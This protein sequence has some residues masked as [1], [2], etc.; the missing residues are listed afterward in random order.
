MGSPLFQKINTLYRQLPKLSCKGCGTCC[1]SPTCT[2]SEF[3]FL[4]DFL[5]KNWKKDVLKKHIL[6]PVEV[7]QQ[8]EGNIVCTFLNDN[9][10]TVYP[11]R[12]G[13]CRLFGIPALESLNIPNLVGCKEHISSPGIEIEVSFL[14]NWLLSLVQLDSSFYEFGKDPYFIRGFNIPCWLDIYFDDSLDFDIFNDIKKAMFSHIDLSFCKNEYTIKTDIR[15]KFDKIAV[16]SSL[17]DS[18]DVQTVKKVLLSIRD[19]Y[20]ATGTYFFEETMIFLSF[21]EKNAGSHKNGTPQISVPKDEVSHLY[22]FYNQISGPPSSKKKGDD[23]IVNTY[24]NNLMVD[25]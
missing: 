12:T 5:C 22:S 14:K 20:P 19:D 13:A 21:I 23:P 24:L 10:C 15:D 8:Y 7:H 4:F 16:V 3:L 17:L 1:V 18:G 9:Q 11:A 2:L 6:A 25:K